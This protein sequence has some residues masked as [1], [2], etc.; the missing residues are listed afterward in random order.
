MD[1]GHNTIGIEV[2]T[3]MHLHRKILEHS[4]YF[5]TYINFHGYMYYKS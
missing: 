4:R 2:L 1:S 3:R 5:M